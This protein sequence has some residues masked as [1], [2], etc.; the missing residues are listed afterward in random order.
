MK[1]SAGLER[2]LLTLKDAAGQLAICRRTLER[3]IARGRFPRPVKIGSGVR[4]PVGD[5]DVYLE[6]LES[7]RDLLQ[8]EP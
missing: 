4:I 5:L 3:E 2:K 7:E 8:T 6:R 1:S